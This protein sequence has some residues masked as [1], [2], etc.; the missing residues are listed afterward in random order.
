MR[1]QTWLSTVYTQNHAYN[2][3]SEINNKRGNEINN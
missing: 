1:E 3:A 2:I